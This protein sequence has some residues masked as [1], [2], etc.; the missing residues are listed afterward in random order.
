MNHEPRLRY[1][2]DGGEFIDNFI[3]FKVVMPSPKA[4]KDYIVLVTFSD[5][6][7]VIIAR[8]KPEDNFKNGRFHY[9]DKI[10]DK[11]VIAWRSL[12]RVPSTIEIDLSKYKIGFEKYIDIK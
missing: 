11:Y 2:I 9:Q 1:Y 6:H 10:I 3:S 12:P 4:V 5:F 8:W 7:K